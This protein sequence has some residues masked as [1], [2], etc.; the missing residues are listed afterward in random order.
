[1][2]SLAETALMGFPESIF[3]PRCQPKPG[4]AYLRMPESLRDL[5]KELKSSD[6]EK[7]RLDDDIFGIMTAKGKKIY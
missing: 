4:Q 6:L 2:I 1:M 5:L 7:I 3:S